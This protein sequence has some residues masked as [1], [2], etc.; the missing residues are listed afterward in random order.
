MTSQR[1]RPVADEDAVRG[2]LA[3]VRQPADAI[4]DRWSL[5]LVCHLLAGERRFGDLEQSSGVA[6][7]L[8]ASRL[9][10]LRSLGVVD[11]RRYSD[12][13]QRYAYFLTPMGR[14]L[15][16]VL[17]QMAGWEERWATGPDR[18]IDASGDGLLGDLPTSTLCAHCRRP[19][20]ARDVTFRIE[21]LQTPRAPP[22][23]TVRRRSK[24][25]RQEAAAGWRPLGES[26]AIFGDKWGIEILICAF[27][28]IRRFNAFRS[29]TGISPNILSDRLGRL[30]AA[31]LLAESWPGGAERGYWL[32]EKGRDVYPVTLAVQT[33]ADRW[34]PDRI[35][36]PV[37][38]V[39]GVCGQEVLL[40]ASLQVQ[41]QKPTP[42]QA[43][44]TP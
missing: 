11:R 4:C 23:Q 34:L 28:G 42:D 21:P 8:V 44:R 43:V 22:K 35:R 31:G 10:A 27:F 3:A 20:A 26:L 39:H 30:T 38:L 18:H 6:S 9:A 1:G 5:E 40:L 12:T 29:A 25:L 32:T 24:T 36:S 41:S 15:R 7:R 37:R 17:G 19:I 2:T 13:P 33:W 14:E 16:A